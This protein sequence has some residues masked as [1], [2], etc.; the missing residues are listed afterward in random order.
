VLDKRDVV[1]ASTTAPHGT[2]PFQGDDLEDE[3][4]LQDDMPSP[5]TVPLLHAPHR[6]DTIVSSAHDRKNS[7]ICATHLDEDEALRLAHESVVRDEEGAPYPLSTPT[8]KLAKLGT[9][10]SLYF[11]FVYYAGLA[12][13]VMSL[14]TLPVMISNFNG[15][16]AFDPTEQIHFPNNLIVA[17]SLGNRPPH[18]PVHLH[19]IMD[20]LC[21]LAFLG[22][23]VYYRRRQLLARKEVETKVI[24][25]ADY[26]VHAKGL[27]EDASKEEI[28]EHF[29]K[30]GEIEQVLVSYHGYKDRSRLLEQRA[31]AEEDVE[32]FTLQ[33][34]SP[35]ETPGAQ[36]GLAAAQRL[37]DKTTGEL[38]KLQRTHARNPR[39]C[40]HA[41][42]TFKLWSAA[43]KCRDVYKVNRSWFLSALTKEAP[44]LFRGALQ[45]KVK[46]APQPSDIMWENLEVSSSSRALRLWATSLFSLVL[47]LLAT[48]CIAGVNGK[49]FFLPIKPLPFVFV[50]LISIVSIVIIII[51]NVTM[52]VTL[53]ILTTFEAHSTKST[54]EV[55]IMLRLWFFQVLNTLM[56]AFMFWDASHNTE[57]KTNWAHWFSD[58]GTMLMGVIIG[59]A[60][61][62]NVV[63]LYR[64]FDVILPRKMGGPKCITQKQLN[65]VYEAPELSLGM[66]YQMIMKHFTLALA[67]GSALPLSYWLITLLCAATFWIDKYNVLRL[68]KKPAH[69]NEDVANVATV[70]VA[71]LSLLLHLCLASYFY[72]V[73]VLCPYELV[74]A[75]SSELMVTYIL[76]CSAAAIVVLVWHPLLYREPTD[77]QYHEVRSKEVL[78]SY[79]EGIERYQP[80]NDWQE[81]AWDGAGAGGEIGISVF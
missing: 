53:P 59:D 78:Y 21:T 74:C 40:G 3:L 67:L 19:S 62:M 75:P 35:V 10:V 30:F 50:G 66:R 48:S 14:I 80:P 2:I 38:L 63:E 71:P 39:C 49:H 16:Y 28:Q 73:V 76:M 29:S 55:H 31:K 9:G 77:V 5:E 33:I 22:F 45:I 25:A 79:V 24:T 60:V 54:I 46:M 18:Q 65:R 36:D 15:I 11:F 7:Q 32:Q 26:T 64:P 13:G 57:G 41:F 69:T 34:A 47:L 8:T 43:H 52:F 23:L 44:A 51:S 68:Y 20:F 81:D 27:P 1:A 4:H 17:T 70:Y 61:L 72:T 58:G 56:G 12:L 42:V 6:S 37:V